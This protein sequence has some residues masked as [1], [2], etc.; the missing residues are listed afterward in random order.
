MGHHSVLS[1]IAV[2][3]LA[4]LFGMRWN[5]GLNVGNY[6]Y[7]AAQC[8][9]FYGLGSILCGLLAVGVKHRG[10]ARYLYTAVTAAADMGLL[11]TISRCPLHYSES[12]A[13]VAIAA[14]VNTIFVATLLILWRA[15]K[16]NKTRP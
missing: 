5:A 8:L 7:A 11:I 15:E 12:V 4:A 10:F 3:G 2:L 13:V 14:V 6:D 1:V 16:K 9:M